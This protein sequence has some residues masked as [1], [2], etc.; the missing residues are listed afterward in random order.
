[1]YVMPMKP[2]PLAE[3][4][5]PKV[6]K[7]GPDECWPWI[8]AVNKQTGYGQIY[9]GRVMIGAHRAVYLLEVGP[10]PDGMTL[11]HRCNRRTCV[12]PT[13]LSPCTTQVNTQLAVDRRDACRRN[14]PRA[15]NT[16]FDRNGTARCRA[17]N[18]QRAKV[19]RDRKKASAQ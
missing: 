5:W 19:Y 4:F 8:G 12:N 10:I 18:T 1:M 6:D 3:R 9:D 14:H 7:R 11:D 15:A 13:H 17:C 2:K 16:Y